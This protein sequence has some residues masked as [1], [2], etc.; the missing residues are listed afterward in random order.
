MNRNFW[1]KLS[2][3]NVFTKNDDGND[4]ECVQSV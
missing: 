1:S 2:D 3:A 4:R